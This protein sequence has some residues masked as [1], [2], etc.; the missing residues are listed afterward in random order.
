MDET[1]V[2]DIALLELDRPFNFDNKYI[3]A[4]GLWDSTWKL[5]GRKGCGILLYSMLHFLPG[6]K[7]ST[8]NKFF[9]LQ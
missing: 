5:P 6:P 4:V 1:P 8:I 2:N 9:E 3:R 7:R